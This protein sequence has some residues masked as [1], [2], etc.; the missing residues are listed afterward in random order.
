MYRHLH[1]ELRKISREI[2]TLLGTQMSFKM[3]CYFGWIAIDLRIIFFAMLINNY[4]KT[5][6]YMCAILHFVWFS[7]NVLKF[8]LINYVCETV[9]IKVFNFEKLLLKIYF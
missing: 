9:N 4:V 1:L 6:K 8:L 2:D 7:H 5:N 3:A